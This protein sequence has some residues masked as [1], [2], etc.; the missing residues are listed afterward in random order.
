M[1]NNI[2]KNIMLALSVLGLSS[3]GYSIQAIQDEFINF[4]EGKGIEVKGTSLDSCATCHQPAIPSLGFLNKYGHALKL[5]DR[6]FEAIENA[7]SDNDNDKKEGTNVLGI[8]NIEEIRRGTNPGSQSENG[9]VFI[10]E[11]PAGFAQKVT[12]PHDY[13]ASIVKAYFNKGCNTCHTQDTYKKEFD[14][15][16][17]VQPTQNKAHTL[18]VQCHEE[19][20]IP[21]TLEFPPFDDTGYPTS[22]SGC[23]G[24]HELPPRP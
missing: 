21:A 23:F 11:P 10:F 7:N 8:T 3:V 6:N 18:C 13:H 19:N 4:Y 14:D 1:K 22:Q 16:K 12:F 20:G 17:V 2:Q 9:G 5:N 24:C 15:R